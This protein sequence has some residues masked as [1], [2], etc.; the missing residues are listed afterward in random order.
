MDDDVKIF[1]DNAT[2]EK[3]QS[4]LGECGW[5]LTDKEGKT[6]KGNRI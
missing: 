3:L 4:L 2:E 5:S 6:K 1:G